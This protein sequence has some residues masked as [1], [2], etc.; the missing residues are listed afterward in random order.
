MFFDSAAY[1]GPLALPF[2]V[3]PGDSLAIPVT[4]APN[5]LDTVDAQLSLVH[6]GI[7]GLSTVYLTG[8][9]IAEGT[10]LQGPTAAPMA[11]SVYP[12]PATGTA[13]L[14]CLAP[15]HAEA[16]LYIFD[17]LG[18]P[19]FEGPLRLVPG[20]NRVPLPIEG[21]PT[22]VYAVG[23]RGVPFVRLVKH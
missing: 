4:F 1:T 6:N 15:A 22:G 13:T 23:L 5:R 12:N 17:A 9:G 2:T 3:P 11:L 8:V 21:L 16:R 20:R 7:F 19:V 18:R 14:E 10:G